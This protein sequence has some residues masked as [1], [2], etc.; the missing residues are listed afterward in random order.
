LWTVE[1]I[2]AGPET[3]DLLAS[4]LAIATIKTTSRFCASS[5]GDRLFFRHHVSP[6]DRLV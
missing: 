6:D 4:D 5:G 2:G 1:A 3:S